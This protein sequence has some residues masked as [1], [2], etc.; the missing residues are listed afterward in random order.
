MPAGISGVRP[1]RT[2]TL[3]AMMALPMNMNGRNLPNLP[4]VRSISTPMMGS[5]KASNTRMPVTMTDANR[6]PR[7]STLAPKVAM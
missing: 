2:R 3:T 6:V 7:L 4:L 5:V 1:Y